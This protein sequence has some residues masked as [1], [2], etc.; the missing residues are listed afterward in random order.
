MSKSYTPWENSDGFNELYKLRQ[1]QGAK[2]ADL[3][4]ELA[5][6]APEVRFRFTSPHPKNFPLNLLQLIAETPNI[7]NSIH[8]PAQSGSTSML[9]RMRRNH[10]R[11]SYL[12]LVDRI[13]S[14]IPGVSIS[15]DMIVG[16]CDETEQEF[17][18]TLS[19]VEQVQ[20]DFGFLFAYSMRERTHAHRRMEDNVPQKVKNE[21]LQELIRVFREH[22]LV[23]NKAEIG[24]HQL[25]LV[26]GRGKFKN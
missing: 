19:L 11:E 10:S 1:S 9:K 22:Q 12:E 3:L 15:T 5:N 20:Y 17:Q 18:D 4:H 21:R 26:D 25:V 8:L 16:F 2:F 13:R 7:C 6:E 23:R 14:E 24:T